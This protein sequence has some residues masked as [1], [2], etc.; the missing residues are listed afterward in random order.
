MARKSNKLT[1]KDFAKELEELAA[2]LRRTIEAECV[3]FDPSA[4]AIAERRARVFDPVSGY[5]YFVEHYFPHYVR[6]ADK[7]E[8]HKYLF[9]RLPEIIASPKGENDAIAAPRGEAKSTLVSQLFSIWCIVCGFKHY[10]VI[11]MDSIDQ[12]Y[13]MLEAIKA[14]LAFNPRV[15]MDFPEVAGGGRVWQAG[16]IVTRNDIKVQVAGSGKKLRGLR[17]GPYRPDLVVLDDIENDEQV[18]SP[19]QRDKLD[20]WLKKTILPLGGAGAKF[21]VIYIGTILHYDSV[22]SRTLKN[23]LWKAARF[24]AVIQWPVNLSLWEEWEEILRNNDSNGEWMASAFYQNHKLEM[25]DGAVVSW[26]A[27]PILTLMLI[28]ARDGHSTFDSE[29]QN[30]PVSGEDA[31]FAHCI[32]FWINR[33]NEWIFFGACDPSLGKAGASRDPSALLVG[34]FNRHTGILDVVEAAIRKRLPD[35]IIS[36]VIELQRIYACLVWSIE[37]VQF[38]EFLRTELVK[39]SAAVGI[40]VPARA[41]QP[42]SDKLLRIESL[43]PHMANGLIRLH[44]S[45]STLIDQLRH[46]PMADHDDGPDALHMLWALAVSGVG[47]FSFTAVP[48]RNSDDRGSRFGSGGW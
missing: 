38:Q 31:P 40:P 41:V 34:G 35:K 30:D 43:Q 25:D 14:E 17:H 42:H 33:L 37:S 47:A 23:P 21:D 10:L 18:R 39:R 11:V 12:A 36:D 5:D 20:N 46:F 2:T 1:A 22:L 29:Y 44:P 19:E 13:P 24:K 48:R 8:L 3:G 26:S 27:R 32:N 4:A 15:E 16:T 6:H 9:T 28:R 45:Q 7:S